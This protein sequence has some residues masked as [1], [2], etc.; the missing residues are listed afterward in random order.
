[1]KGLVYAIP[2]K[3]MR[4]GFAILLKHKGKEEQEERIAEIL[5]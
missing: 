4:P 1:M 5:S 2:R 3:R